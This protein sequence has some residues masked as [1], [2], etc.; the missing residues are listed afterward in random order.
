MP[1]RSTV[2]SEDIDD[3][4]HHIQLDEHVKDWPDVPVCLQESH[5]HGSCLEASRAEMDAMTCEIELLRTQMDRL[6]EENITLIEVESSLSLPTFSIENVK[7][8]EKLMTFYTGF[9]SLC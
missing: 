9:S 6:K 4:F 3:G 2:G 7:P 8:E 5:E 1:A